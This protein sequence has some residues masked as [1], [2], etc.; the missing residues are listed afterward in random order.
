MPPPL[1]I[2][3]PPNG[4]VCFTGKAFLFSPKID[5]EKPTSNFFSVVTPPNMVATGNAISF[6]STFTS[7]VSGTFG[8][9]ILVSPSTLKS[10]FCF[11]SSMDFD[12]VGFNPKSDTL[13]YS[14]DGLKGISF[15]FVGIF[16]LL[17]PCP[18]TSLLGGIIF[19][20][21]GTLFP[22]NL[23]SRRSKSVLRS[24]SSIY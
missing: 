19:S 2:A 10:Y 21:F 24:L 15:A 1:L 11:D 13:D 9:R 4:G 8:I 23:L 12:S 6:D 20:K 17:F 7:L 18:N 14:A 5:F 22:S 16:G 3:P